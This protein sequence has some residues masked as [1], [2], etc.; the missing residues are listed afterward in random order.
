MNR[1]EK[2]IRGCPPTSISHHHPHHIA[3]QLRKASRPLF[4]GS[5]RPAGM[6]ALR[7]TGPVA[8][9]R[10]LRPHRLIRRKTPVS[11]RKRTHE[12]PFG[13]KDIR[14]GLRARDIRFAASLQVRTGELPSSLQQFVDRPQLHGG[15][16]VE[17]CGA[18]SAA[19]VSQRPHIVLAYG[20]PHAFV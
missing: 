16:A 12:T 20:R 19:Y 2:T 11:R 1:Q 7:H 13:R 8:R 15:L 3:P 5:L 14:I 4:R 10:S 17:F 6:T 18:G 9:R